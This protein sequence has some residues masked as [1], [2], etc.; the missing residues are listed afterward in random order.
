MKINETT[1]MNEKLTQIYNLAK[2]KVIGFFKKNR[3]YI[4]SY[5]VLFCVLLFDLITK[6][7]ASNRLILNG[8]AVPFIPNFLYFKYTHNF[9]IA[10]GL[11]PAESLWTRVLLVIITSIMAS[12]FIFGMI[13][14]RRENMW[15]KIAFALIIAGALGNIFDRMFYG[16]VRDFLQFGGFLNWFSFIFNVADVSLI[17][18]VIM[19]GIWLIFMFRPHRNFVGPVLPKEEAVVEKV[20]NIAEG[21]DETNS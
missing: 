18:G 12:G 8:L 6:A 17:V 4:I 1:S 2:P 11:F 14:F 20:E 10:F 15:S 5:S 13:R 16:Y 19:L 3:A 7:V 9:G 21:E